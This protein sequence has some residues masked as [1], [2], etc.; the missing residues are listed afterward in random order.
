MTR[1]PRGKRYADDEMD[2][3]ENAAREHPHARAPRERLW[4]PQ[5]PG[6][7]YRV[8]L[9]LIVSVLGLLVWFNRGNLTPANISEWIQSRV[10]CIGV[11]DGFPSP[12]SNGRVVL[13]G[14]FASQDKNAVIV[15]DTALTIL[16]STAKELVRRQHSF[17]NPVMR[18]AGSRVMIYNLGGKGYQIEGYSKTLR[19]GSTD[20]NIQ[21]G[22][23]A[24][25]GRYALATENKGYASRLTVYLSSGAPQY[26]YDFSD[27]YVTQVALNRSGTRAAVAAVSAS[28][29]GMVSAVYL[30]DFGN[31]KPVKILTYPENLV[32]SLSYGENG[33]IVAVGDRLTSVIREDGGKT[34]YDYKGR[35]LLTAASGNGRTALAL[36]P[37]ANASSGS[38]VLLDSSGRQTAAIP[39][40]HRAKAVAL[41]GDAAAV[42]TNDGTAW[43][44]DA[45]T[46]AARGS[47]SAGSDARTLALHDESS[48]YVLGVS[49]IRLVTFRSGGA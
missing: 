23:L 20:E 32:L 22:A 40:K 27:Y 4:F 36:I 41:Y 44:Y 19:K 3:D 5:V 2:R 16:N 21:A 46:G 17:S 39:L 30:F 31:P 28:D 42:L 34:D 33:S 18:T 49:E 8:A 48:A 12:V 9:I 1:K 43:A 29:G 37:Y 15:S 47:C 45:S 13:A 14:N 35:P 7:V 10:V 38:L 11:G 25:N 6:W 24:P 26:V